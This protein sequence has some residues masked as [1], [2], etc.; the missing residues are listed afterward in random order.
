[1]EEDGMSGLYLIAVFAIWLF[2]GRIVY[3]LWCYW[4]PVD[5]TRKI[6]HVTFGGILL[7]VWF[8]GA[9]WEV[10]GKKIYW[11][12]K[13]RELC[14]KDGGVKVYET[15]TL[16]AE[17]FDKYGKVHIPSKSFS[18]PEDEYYVLREELYYRKGDP[19]V[20][21]DQAR[22]IRRRDGKVLGEEI[23]YGR[24]GGDL[25][26]FWHDSSFRCPKSTIFESA[27]FLKGAN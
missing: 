25:P 26:G 5:L 11:D 27:I 14:A 7:L 16:P 8:G 2:V 12:A 13:V 22:I 9:F 15:V 18:K 3:R 4:K 6:V 19:Q 21:R 23:S 10:A 20:T 24:R 1:M 17:K